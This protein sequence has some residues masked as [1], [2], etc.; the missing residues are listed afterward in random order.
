MNEVATDYNSGF[1]G[2]VAA[3]YAQYGGAALPESEFPPAVQPLDDEYLVGAK[4][5]SSGSHHIEIRAVVQN[6]STTDRKSTRLNSSHVAISYA[7]FCLKK[8]KKT[9]KHKP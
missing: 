4:I 1:T 8:K 3:L 6:R 2:A 9:I 5:N 7:V